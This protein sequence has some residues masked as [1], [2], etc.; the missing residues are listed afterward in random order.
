MNNPL[1]EFFRTPGDQGQEIINCGVSQQKK[2]G[3]QYLRDRE[4]WVNTET[5]F[6]KVVS[7]VTKYIQPNENVEKSRTL[8]RLRY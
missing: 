2:N 7:V 1:K 6:R 3:A 5:T 8:D 4:S